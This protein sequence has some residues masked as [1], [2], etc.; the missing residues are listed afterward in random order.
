MSSTATDVRH[1]AKFSDVLLT[2]FAEL[3]PPDRYVRVLDPFAGTGK[4]HQLPNHTIGL[5]IEREWA[6]MHSDTM[7]GDV[8]S[9]PEAWFGSGRFDA[10]CT[11]P[12]YGNRFA[13]HHEANDGS[14]RRSYRHD[15]GRMPSAG[16]SATMQWGD[17]Y[18]QF[19]IDA[20]RK[21]AQVLKPGGRFVLNI[22]DHVR[23]GKV[24]PVG[25]WHVGVL[26]GVLGVIPTWEIP[27]QTPRLR[28]GENGELRVEH[29]MIYVWDTEPFEDWGG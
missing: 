27:V 20:W 2:H 22:S 24:Q 21:V 25:A 8:M 18:R 3:L 13:D 7:V 14:R 26:S 29:E 12:C 15:L 9:M 5:E 19:H 4:I 17:Q 11:S 1:P 16:S 28:D 6:R 10:I 23:G